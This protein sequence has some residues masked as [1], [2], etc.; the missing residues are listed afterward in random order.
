[1]S[2]HET[3]LSGRVATDEEAMA[4]AVRSALAGVAEGQSPFGCCVVKD[5]RVLASDHNRVWE[6]NDPTAHAEVNAIRAACRELETFDLSGCVLY[7]TCEPCPMCYSAA[8]WARVS[9]IVFGA[10]I[11]DARKAGF[12]ELAIPAGKM[13]ELSS[14]EVE[15]VAGYMAGE[16][17][18]VFTTWARLGNGK[19][20]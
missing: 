6:R 2:E 4:L 8:H 16:C 15:I 7:A 11:D 3:V 18:N 1:M 20:Y 5:G 13:K 19:T 9:K 17:R 12:N 10:G 14:D